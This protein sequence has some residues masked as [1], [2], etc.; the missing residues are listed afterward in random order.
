MKF[1]SLLF[2]LSTSVAAAPSGSA[3][4]QLH[5]ENPHYFV[6]RGQPTVLVGSSEHYGAVINLDFDYTKYLAATQ[7]AGLNATRIF[8][9]P[10]RELPGKFTPNSDFEIKDNTLAPK[11]QRFLAPWPRARNEPGKFDLSRWDQTYFKRL[12]DLVSEAGRRGIVVEVSLFSPYYGENLWDISPFNS[13][14]NINGVGNVLRRDV[15]TLKDPR[16][17][18]VEEK[19]V[20]EIV[21]ELRGFDNV[22]YEI[23]NE[24]Y[25]GDVPSD[26]QTRIA[27]VIVDVESNLPVRHLIAQEISTDERKV[28]NPVPQASL[29]L[30]HGTRS[31]ATVRLNYELGKPLGSNESGF[32][33]IAPAPYRIQAWQYLLAGGALTIGLDY[34]FTIDHPEGSFQIP[35]TQPGGGGTELRKQLGILR[36]FM[37]SMNVLKMVPTATVVQSGVPVNASISAL[38]DPGKVYA[39]YIHHGHEQAWKTFKDPRFTVDHGHQIAKL[40]VNLLPGK[41]RAQWL[42]TKTGVVDKEE[43]LTTQTGSAV[44]ASPE[45]DED[46]ALRV[47]AASD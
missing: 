31:S 39:V 26:W 38:A 17:L 15:L 36:Q 24:P 35:L 8:V 16:V 11:A 37:S 43:P 9:G 33:G 7:R 41:Y 34:S 10:Y 21:G 2:A 5:P 27:E 3:P 29:Y 1:F 30:F 23:C 45:Y 28:A 6:F 46:I 32:D 12:K 18:A 25:L 19:M 47:T 40:G 20:R 22:Y 44:L 4:L 14:N 13:K 42:N